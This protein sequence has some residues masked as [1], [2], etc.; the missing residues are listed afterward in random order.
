MLRHRIWSRLRFPLLLLIILFGFY[1]KLT[2]TRQYDWLWGPDL[3][4]QILPW[5]D[6]EARQWHHRTFPIWDTH[7][8]TGQSLI[9]Q[10]QPGVAYP[11][12]WLLWSLPLKN[13]HLQMGS[14][15]WYY[16]AIH[17]MA[18][19]FCYW[20]CRDLGRSPTASLAAGLVFSLASYVGLTDWPQMLNGAVWTP[21]VFLFLL[22]AER[23]YRPWTSA[24]LCGSSL[25]MA[26]LSGHHQ[27]PILLTL[28][29]IGS[30]AYFAYGNRFLIRYAAFSMIVMG[31]VGALQ[32]LP[33]QE[34]G[35]LSLRWVGAQNPVGWRDAVPYYV[36]GQFSLYPFQLFGLIVPGSN[37]HF[38]PYLGVV[39]VTLALLGIALGWKDRSVKLFAALALAG[40]IYALGKYSVFQGFLYALAP[41]VE[42]ARVPVASIFLTGCGAAVLLATGIDAI[43]ENAGHMWVRRF[44]LATGGYALVTGLILYGIF[45]GKKLGWD[46]DDRIFLSVFVAILLCALLSAWRSGNLTMRSAGVLLILLLLFELGTNAGFKLSPRAEAGQRVF[47]ERTVNNADLAQWLHA[48]RGTFRIETK[49]DEFPANWGIYHNLDV[50]HTYAGVTSNILDVD[51][52]L[53]NGRMLLNTRYTLAKEPADPGEKE[54]FTGKSGMKIYENPDAFPRAWAVREVEKMDSDQGHWMIANRLPELRSKAFTKQTVPKLPACSED[55]GI[56]EVQQYSSLSVS[57]RAAMNCD[58]MVILSDNYYPGWQATVDGKRAQTYEV[59]FAFRGVAVPKGTHQVAFRYRPGSVYLGAFLTLA[60]VLLTAFVWRWE[61]RRLET[62]E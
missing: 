36:H 28:A 18:A 5:V 19:W 57:L 47:R 32:I 20:L 30:W 29:A 61:R 13:G 56:V 25:G 45:I 11:L 58:G 51:D 4:Q 9:G 24:A 55:A 21:L 41:F 48:Q 54:V 7:E 34:Y 1:W 26:W 10:A 6:E 53:W 8:W 62:A 37:A 15:Q 60:G 40:L 43:T 33:A 3:T 16:L 14:L 23:G 52:N 17:F 46:S 42:K 35:R 2:L 38:D 50:V 27:V 44:A 59:D 49:D 31:L 12:N 39:A 22:R